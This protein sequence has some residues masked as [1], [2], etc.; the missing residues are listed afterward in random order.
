M[1]ALVQYILN[2][3]AAGK[4][5]LLAADAAAQKTLLSLTKSDVGLGNVDNT[6]DASKPV[7]SAQAAAISA[8]ALQTITITAGTG[9]SGGGDLSANRTLSLANTAVTPG[10]YTAANVTVDAQ[11]RI[12][13]AANGSAGI[14]GSV[15]TTDNRLVKS[16]GT[17]G[18]T[19]QSTGITVDASNNVSGVGTISS[20]R[21]TTPSVLL[22][23]NFSTTAWTTNGVGI[24]HT[25]R[26][27]TDTSS[28]GTVAAAYTNVLGGNTIAASVATTFTTYAS[29]FLGSPTAGANVTITNPW[30]LVTQ[31]GISCGGA[32]TASGL[33]TA[34]GDLQVGTATENITLQ[35]NTSSVISAYSNSLGAHYQLIG[36]STGSGGPMIF[37]IG[38]GGTFEYRSTNRADAGTTDLAFGRDAANVF[39]IYTNSTKTTKADLT[40]RAITASGLLTANGGEKGTALL[41]AALPAASA[42]TDVEYIVSDRTNRPKV[43]SDGTNWR[44]LYDGSILT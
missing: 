4:A 28:S 43:K 19:V 32:I 27:L 18:S 39:G 38:A 25:A 9:L 41:F 44:N 1:K 8:R 42:N 33:I 30:S 34:A 15:G 21:V 6:A 12:T 7:S 14:G 16:S 2:A 17:G 37:R 5:W 23:G 31:G 20:G 40:C 10:S 24:A 29:L 11:G 22:S 3:T 35:S 36:D 26:T 13:A